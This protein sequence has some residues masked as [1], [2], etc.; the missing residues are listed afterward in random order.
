MIR[1]NELYEELLE[2]EETERKECYG[3]GISLTFKIVFIR[4]GL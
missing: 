2:T 3:K 4:L 1:C